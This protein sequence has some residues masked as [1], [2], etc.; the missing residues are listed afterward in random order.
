ML[1][2]KWHV[3]VSYVHLYL[4]KNVIFMWTGGLKL[5]QCMIF[6]V[7]KSSKS[8]AKS[9]RYDRIRYSSSSV[10]NQIFRKLLQLI[11]HNFQLFEHSAFSGCG[12]SI[13]I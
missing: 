1:I 6:I 10:G 13:V 2:L 9:P 5:K 7:H 12:S 8:Y 3:Y 4:L 11:E